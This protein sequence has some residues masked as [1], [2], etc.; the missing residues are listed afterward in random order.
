[1]PSATPTKPDR[2]PLPRWLV[3]LLALTSAGLLLW[4]LWLTYSLPSRHVTQHYDLAWVGFD[5]ALLVGVRRDRL[6][7]V[8]SSPVARA[9]GGG[10]RDDAGL[11]RVVRHRHVGSRASAWRPCSRRRSPSCRSLRSAGSS[12]STS[13]AS[14]RRLILRYPG[15]VSRIL[16]ERVLGGDSPRRCAARAGADG[17]RA[18]RREAR[19][20]RDRR[21]TTR[22]RSSTSACTAPSACSESFARLPRTRAGS[23]RM[24]SSIAS[25]IRSLP[26]AAMR[27]R[28]AALAPL[29]ARAPVR[30]GSG[31]APVS[32]VDEL[33]CRLGGERLL[34]RL[35]QRR[36]PTSSLPRPRRPPTVAPISSPGASRF[37]FAN[38]GSRS[39]QIV[40]SGAAMKI[41][42][43]APEM[44]PTMSANAKSLS[45][46]PPK[47]S[48]ATIGSSVMNVVASDRR[49]VS[50]SETF[51]DRRERL[52]AHQRDVLAHA[53]E[54]DDRVVDRVAEYRQDRR[55]GRDR[56]LLVRDRVD[57][58]GDDDVVQHRE[59]HRHRELRAEPQR[60]V[61][62][63]QDERDDDPPDRVDCDLVAEAR[64]DV[65]DARRVGAELR[66]QVGRTAFDWVGPVSDSRPDLPLRVLA[67]RSAVPRPWTIAVF[68][69]VLRRDLP[70]LVG[71]D[72][73]CAS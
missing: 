60:D 36:L 4:T 34:G 43:Y 11:R 31:G 10:D 6:C 33:R 28:A 67:V 64:R 46:G 42:E 69:T 5:I 54:D 26:R 35:E 15:T 57:A 44:T 19:A 20:R 1:M 8:R 25:T 24:S 63:D 39:F 14:G 66:L 53:V 47:I 13:S 30:P 21:A 56:D 22:F 40:S 61:D 2:L 48:S 3:P 7:A 49:I 68:S 9:R 18:A 65:L 70:H 51:D 41:D 32:D 62:H 58:D 37:R 71:R 38:S 12:S 17:A 29:L 50:H 16:R 27:P 59:D 73:P 55:D 45:V 52:A 72:T 23:S